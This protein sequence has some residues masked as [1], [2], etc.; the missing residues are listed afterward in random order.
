MADG[1]ESS[2]NKLDCCNC[3][4]VELLES[5]DGDS[6]PAGGDSVLSVVERVSFM[7][8]GTLDG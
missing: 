4:T 8:R 3:W 2:P 7:I 1:D 6:I 5:T